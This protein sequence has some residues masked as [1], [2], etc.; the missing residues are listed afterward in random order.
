MNKIKLNFNDKFF[1]FHFGL[2]FMGVLLDDL[3]CSIDELM[4]GIQ[5][6]PFKFIPKLMHSS[7]S[8]NLKREGKE[9]EL[10][11]Y[12]FTDFLDE[13]GG[14]MSKTVNLFLEA[15]TSSMT[16]DVPKEP[17]KIPSKGKRKANL[18]K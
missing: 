1:G 15:F 7:Y 10:N 9:I 17:N 13:N 18:K 11:I 5:S 4:E 14:I 6:N 16:K 2:G 12:D 3:N 8:Y